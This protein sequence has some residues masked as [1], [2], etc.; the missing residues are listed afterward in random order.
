[1][2]AVRHRIRSI[3]ATKRWSGA[4]L[5]RQMQPPESREWISARLKEEGVDWGLADVYRAA[6]ALGV[7][8]GVLLGT[9]APP[10]PHLFVDAFEAHKTG[11]KVSETTSPAWSTGVMDEVIERDRRFYAALFQEGVLHSI[12]R[13]PPKDRGI[14]MR[15]IGII[16]DMLDKAEEA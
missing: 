1:M 3:L 15:M 12:N 5:G 7:E 2:E 10:I 9:Q 6:D 4:E 13:L 11:G 16:D 14:V 8:A